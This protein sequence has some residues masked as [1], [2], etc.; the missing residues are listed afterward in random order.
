[1]EEEGSKEA[2]NASPNDGGKIKQILL[3]VKSNTNT[4][5]SF[6]NSRSGTSVSSLTSIDELENDDNI[7]GGVEKKVMVATIFQKNKDDIDCFLAGIP[8]KVKV[9]E[10]IRTPRSHVLNPNLYTIELQHGGFH[11]T[12]RRR[13]RHFLRLHTELVIAKATSQLPT[14]KREKIKCKLPSFPRRPEI[15]V[16]GQKQLEK[17]K[18]ALEK[19]LRGVLNLHEIRNE[20]EVLEFAEISIASFLYDCGQKK[21]ESMVEKRAGGRRAAAGI[22]G[23]MN[24]GSCHWN[25]RPKTRIIRDLLLFDSNFTVKSGRKHS[26]HRSGLV[27][28]ND[29]RDL[30]VKCQSQRDSREWVTAIAK[31]MAGSGSDWLKEH[32]HDSFAPVRREN[33]VQ[34]FVDAQGYM[35]QV[36]DAITNAEEE[37][38]ITD[39]WLSPELH[40][41][42][43]VTDMN[44]WRL[45]LLLKERAHN[46]VRV[47]VI[48]YKELE[49]ALTIDSNYSKQ[50]LHSLHESNVKVLRHPDHLPGSGTFLWAHHE[51][52]VCIDQ[53]IAFLGGVDLCFGRWDNH[54]HPLT[55]F[56][57]ARPSFLT[58][59]ESTIA[60][61]SRFLVDAFGA[62]PASSSSGDVSAEVD[63]ADKTDQ[64]KL[65]IG[66]DFC[67]PY[68]KDFYELHKPFEDSIDRNLFPRMPWHDIAAVVY[69]A[70]A[71]DVGRHF[72][73]RW[74]FTK[75]LKAKEDEGYPLL[76]PRSYCP[77]PDVKPFDA[78]N[79]I[80]ADCQILRSASRWSA[81]ISTEDSIHKAYIETIRNSK[82][83]IYIENQFFIT[84]LKSEY[85]YNEIG[86]ALVDRIVKAHQN[87]EKFLVLVV[88]PLL[89][90]FPGEIGQPSGSA[91]LIVEHWNYR[92][93]C[94]SPESIYE[95]LKGKGVEDPCKYIRFHGLRTYEDLQGKLVTEA[96]YVHS[97]LMI[98][99]D[100]FV[101]L[102]SANIN[103]RSMLGNRDSEIAIIVQ[104]TEM[105]DSQMDGK[106][107]KAG[108]FAHTLRKWLF[109]EHLGLLSDTERS[110]ADPISDEMINFWRTAAEEN[111][112]IYEESRNRL[113]ESDPTSARQLLRNLQGHIVEKPLH[114]LENQDMR[115][116]AGTAES[117]VPAS[118]FT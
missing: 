18:R 100:R 90:C 26:G 79:T 45:D 55:D 58:K 103:D 67:N 85:V 81:G 42:R 38:F 86:D 44:K 106:H 117:L 40:L 91:K 94:R 17:R 47:Y 4:Y 104:D 75:R 108:Q 43:P 37:I 46:G 78:N 83:F 15:A 41:K 115:P 70:A 102:G 12:I 33:K 53:K 101:I 69:G 113:A 6:T 68:L 19:Y 11:W 84:S 72:I 39:W 24:C 28:S 31:A 50:V 89:P 2:T 74:N 97:K 57:S 76:L 3:T 52:I 112:K 14:T 95:L 22:C 36:A 20:K 65:F 99:D 51:K 7:E 61:M 110:V 48:M 21:K 54:K 93:I 118:V 107:Y 30:T 96:I 10:L 1:M 8:V 116:A 64:S 49:M 63:G 82:H 88:M 56:G 25:E 13:H 73:E 109:R 77:V 105:V 98:V 71:R 5:G 35:E 23:C 92:T 59:T 114:F 111:T 32:H 87:D 60:H 16:I 29:S 62:I 9:T 80:V 66:K 27:I 34:W